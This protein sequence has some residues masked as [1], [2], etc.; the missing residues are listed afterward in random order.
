MQPGLCACSSFDRSRLIQRLLS[1]LSIVLKRKRTFTLPVFGSVIVPMESIRRIRLDEEFAIRDMTAKPS[2]VLSLIQAGKA[3]VMTGHFEYIVGVLKYLDQRKE[4]LVDHSAFAHIENR[5]ERGQRLQDAYR[6][7]LYRLMV[8]ARGNKLLQV[9]HQPRLTGLIRWLEGQD[10]ELYGGRFLIPVRRVLRIASDIKRSEEGMY[11]HALEHK[12]WIFPHVFAPSDQKVVNLLYENLILK[13]NAAVLDVGTGSGIL[14]LIA[15]KK[16]AR[17]VVATDNHPNAV[18]NAR[19]N[20]RKLG[21]EVEV[22]GPCHLFDEVAGERFDVILFNAP[23][24]YGE[25]KS[26]YDTALYDPDYC[27]ITDF[28]RHVGDH[29]KSDGLIYLQY[30]DISQRTGHGALDHL[31][32]LIADNGFEVRRRWATPRLGRTLG[33]REMILLFEIGRVNH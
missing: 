8:V 23:W 3:V 11:I 7:A 17:Q 22:R 33:R 16:G 2:E 12:I 31:D 21:L 10:R 24:I 26:L 32:R 1:A 14:A 28:F 15:A 6:A 4:Q 18:E 30:S 25:P 5:F 13:D 20:A 19:F 29:L 27:V 9:T